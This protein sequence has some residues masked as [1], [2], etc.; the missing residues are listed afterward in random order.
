MS[1]L[2]HRI[3]WNRAPRIA[4]IGRDGRW[5]VADD[6]GG[7]RNEEKEDSDGDE[8]DD[9]A[10]GD[11]YDDDDDDDVLKNRMVSNRPSHDDCIEEAL[12]W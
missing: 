1:P 3:D 10:D 11:R 4:C 12:S 5:T 9:D 2:L 7:R 8:Y 6:G